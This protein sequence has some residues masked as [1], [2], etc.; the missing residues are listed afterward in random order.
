MFIKTDP[1]PKSIACDIRH[2]LKKCKISPNKELGQHFITNRNLLRHEVEYANI[3]SKDRILEIGPG[4][5]NLTELLAQKAKLV[6]AIEKD[7]Q[8]KKCLSSFQKNY[9]NV[10]VIYGD[11]LETNF[12]SFDKVVSN[13]P[14]NIAL[15]L[16]F[17]ILNYS[18]DVAVILCQK[19]LAQRICASAGQKGYCR[20]SVSIQR[21]ADAK[22]LNFVPKSAF[23]PPPEVDGAIV[24]IKKTPK[25]TI[26][27]EEFFR[28]LLKFM[29]SHRDSSVRS[30]LTPKYLR[31]PKQLLAN[32]LSRTG[33][34]INLKMVY[35]VTPRQFG[36]ITWALWKELETHNVTHFVPQPDSI[37]FK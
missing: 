32:V 3:S 13:L 24:R 29:F 14:F 18:F 33:T 16:I 22:I 30:I 27:S 15:P 26:P 8:F 34:K 2:T 17:K 6:I 31:L 21:V 12:P 11:A 7:L 20:L 10:K 37:P 25:F 35:E 19:R 9:D 1:N 23:F 4:I 36:T 5:G 28:E